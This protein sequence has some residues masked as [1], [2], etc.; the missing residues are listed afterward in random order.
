LTAGVELR[1]LERA[2]EGRVVLGD[3]AD[4]ELLRQPAWAQFRHVRP[5]A[6]VL[7]RTPADVAETIALA[8]RTGLETVARSGGHCFAGRSST[9]G[10]LIDLGEMRSVS[11]ADGIA[12]VGA[13]AQLGDVYERLEPLGRTIAAGA[14]PSVGIA[15]LTLGG[16]LGILGRKHGLTS[17]QLVE[18]EVVVADGRVL[19]CDEHRHA[20]LFWALRGAGGGQFGI[21]TRFAFGTVPAEDVTC[22]MLV[23]PFSRA[24]AVIDAWQAWAPDA[25][26]E[27]A[28]SLL[29][30]A[31]G[32]RADPSVTLFGAMIGREDVTARTL[33]EVVT[34][35][36]VE[37]TS[38]TS[39]HLSHGAA[40]RYLA[41]HAPGAEGQDGAPAG[42]PAQPIMVSKSGFFR[43]SLPR[44]AIAALLGTFA[45]GRAQ[46]QAR[47]LDF[48]PWGG[49]YNRRSPEE[50]AF[51]HR[52]ERFL[53][54]HAVVLGPDAPGGERDA[55]GEWLAR[56]LARV[57]RWSSGGVFPNFPDPDLTD[58]TRAYHGANY[59]RLTRIKATYDPDSLFRFH[60]SLPPASVGAPTE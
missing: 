57:A 58:W 17:D 4:Y 19:T 30:N 49:A 35:A 8:R 56:S 2:I 12:T 33:D 31:S 28:A 36:G 44:E 18:A 41:E 51:V 21:V 32:S 50:T 25:A 15:G 22:F 20:D 39:A 23:W 34:R 1:A 38:T 47:E 48:T 37:P 54:K 11:V 53:L 27:L 10:I 24:A 29:V 42:Q 7:C 14:C 55:A 5:V 13:G 40:K 45:A 9:R 26:D 46:G 6:V 59:D 3:S 43:R 60:Q 16:G 52:R